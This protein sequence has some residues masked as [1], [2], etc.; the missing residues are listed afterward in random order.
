LTFS[1]ER[2]YTGEQ[3]D[4]QMGTLHVVGISLDNLEDVTLRALRVLREVNLIVAQ[5]TC[6][7]QGFL[8]HYGIDTP[9]ACYVETETGSACRQ[10][11]TE[12]ESVF[13]ELIGGDVALLF[14]VV[15]ENTLRSAHR[16]VRAAVERGI[17]L[18]SVPGPSAAV[19]ALVA[20]GLPSDAYVSLGFL[21]ECTFE[22]RRLL[23]SLVAERRTLVA[24][25]TSNRLLDAVHDIVETLGDRPLAL[26]SFWP[27]SHEDIWR[28]T[29]NEA[30]VHLETDL[31]RGSW[32]L[33]IGGAEGR[34]VR[35]SE[36]RVRSELVCLLAKGVR[37][38]E[39]TR[40]VAEASGWQPREVYRLATRDEFRL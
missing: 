33:V 29:A 1:L 20:S 24:F 9:L 38:K 13:D 4:A 7:A 39:A 34:K 16:L 36:D 12:A 32:A 2:G 23:A 21:P 19:T 8:A 28:G 27:G 11:F 25:D 5:D 22:R 17:T 3:E 30:T 35:W 26:S 14:E 6:R 40:Q 10:G 18:A 31:L 15:A 37:L